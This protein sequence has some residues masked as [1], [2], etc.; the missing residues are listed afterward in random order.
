MRPL[1]LK[2]LLVWLA[3]LFG[4]SAFAAENHIQEV[5]LA[6]RGQVESVEAD[7][8]SDQ[9][10][11]SGDGQTVVF[12]SYAGNLV[13]DDTNGWPDVFIYDVAK[14]QLQR[15]LANNRTE[16]LVGAYD[17]VISVDGRVIAFRS[18]SPYFG[19]SG[20]SSPANVYLYRRDDD[21]FLPESFIS[22][23][24]TINGSAV[25][26]QSYQ[27]RVSAD[28][29][30]VVYAS[31]ATNLVEG[32][33]NG[34]RDIFV[35]DCLNRTVTRVN[36]ST[37]GG[38]QA[39]GPSAN[40]DISADG[41][42]VVFESSAS[43]LVN[44]DTNGVTDVFLVSLQSGELL[45]VSNGLE[46]VSPNGAS[47]NAAIS[48]EGQFIAFRSAASNL[49]SSDTNGQADIFLVESRKLREPPLRIS[50]ASG[51]GEAN[52][53]SDIP[54][55][56][57]DGN[58]ISFQSAASN[59]VADDRNGYT[60]IFIY[61][62][63]KGSVEL[64]SVTDTGVLLDADSKRAVLSEK[65]A[66]L[67]FVS[68]ASN[69]EDGDLRSKLD[70]FLRD[71]RAERTV[72]VSKSE[73]SF[74]PNGN[75]LYPGISDDG[76]YV[77][78]TSEA[79]NIV[80]KESRFSLGDVFLYDHLTDTVSCISSD[81]SGTPRGAFLGR[82]SG[83]GRYVIFA[84]GAAELIGVGSTPNQALV[85]DVLL[86]TLRVCSKAADGQLAD[87]YVSDLGGV[88][89]DGNICI[90]SSGAGNLGPLNPSHVMQVF[91]R[92]EAANTVTL[93][94]AG[95]GGAPGN[96]S[97]FSSQLSGNGRYVVF[98][99]L[100]SNLVAG[101]TNNTQDVFLYDTQLQSLELVSLNSDNEIANGDSGGP[102][103]S[104]DGRFVVFWSTAT[105]FASGAVGQTSVYLR[106]RVSGTTQL[107]STPPGSSNLVQYGAIPAMS[108]D[109]RFIT[110]CSQSSLFVDGDFNNY[111]DIFLYDRLA[112]SMSLITQ[113]A[114]GI[115]V[116]GDCSNSVIASG[117][118]A[119][120]YN[121]KAR[122]LVDPHT[123]G[124]I[125]VFRAEFAADSCPSDPDK[126]VPGACGCGV[127]DRDANSNGVPDC[128]DPPATPTATPSPTPQ[129]R[130]EEIDITVSLS[131][132][133]KQIAA[134]IKY[135]QSA[136]TLLSR[137]GVSKKVTRA[138]LAKGRG[139]QKKAL[140][141]LAQVPQVVKKQCVPDVCH[142]HSLQAPLTLI[143]TQTRA[144]SKLAGQLAARVS[145]G[146]SQVRKKG[147][148]LVQSSKAAIQAILKTLAALPSETQEC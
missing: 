10:S 124:T 26:G 41:N 17:P 107:I 141:G 114:D 43:N 134:L 51:P 110:F 135:L 40:P 47:G 132:V 6:S 136:T 60:D 42:F 54:R 48:P 61:D 121:S 66:A 111:W 68:Y 100:A 53:A 108:P 125:Q 70:I 35:Y 148:L 82:I 92:D 2:V 78:F 139:Y 21:L 77:V 83:S 85:R 73:P 72:W 87:R 50:V 79:S 113:R 123:S 95:V 143:R 112:D 49:I 28:G 71:R 99:S 76:R 93:V 29:C 128:L 133:Q 45:R 115:Q 5:A 65:G 127:S 90:F 30:R 36:L 94:S 130:C 12:F 56:S 11:I 24:P 122:D 75:S 144:L 9:P 58:F 138:A 74:V 64:A 104:A 38:A 46:G 146:P 37:E 131:L 67:A 52:G 97:S 18:G 14:D 23:S 91:L 118:T 57:S 116:K 80:P 19:T 22:A 105:N 142:A 101:D 8:E 32:D 145:N 25:N 102:G 55:F 15:L 117:A 96:N 44:E 31:D 59:L 63:E 33:T 86:G 20:W 7:N 81:D 89:S 126:Y 1:V 3:I 84:T 147:R 137:T 34:Q 16:P 119:I 120:A 88:S 27:P 106:D 4:A 98:S 13:R 129:V 62:A 103:V 39:N 109:G 69:V 140:G